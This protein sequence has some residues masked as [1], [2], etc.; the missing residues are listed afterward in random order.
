MKSWK[1]NHLPSST[2]QASSS[3]HR[4][5]RRPP[6]IGNHRTTTRT[7][8]ATEPPKRHVDIA[9]ASSPVTPS[10]DLKV[11]VVAER[12]YP[13][14]VHHRSVNLVAGEGEEE[15]SGS[16]TVLF[17]RCAMNNVILPPRPRPTIINGVVLPPRPW[18]PRPL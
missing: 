16:R 14:A 17:C 5:L 7:L 11:F 18:Q 10:K 12:I 6:A 1:P 8:L 15:T 4:R 9:I 3:S 2:A 13:V